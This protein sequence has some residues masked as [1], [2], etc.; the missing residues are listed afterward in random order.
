[1]PASPTWI[2]TIAGDHPA[3]EVAAAL[4]RAG[5]ETTSVLA[6]IGVITGRCPAA[7]VAALR[8]V[9]GVVDVAA[10]APVDVGPPGSPR[11]W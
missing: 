3:A 11:T 5:F 7:K 9:A 4:T 1:M 8:K 2:V 10:D 6:E